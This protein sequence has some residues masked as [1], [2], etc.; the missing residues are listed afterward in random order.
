M[1]QNWTNLKGFVFFHLVQFQNEHPIRKN[2]PGSSKTARVCLWGGGGIFC[3]SSLPT[4]LAHI[5]C[6]SPNFAVQWCWALNLMKPAYQISMFHDELGSWAFKLS[7]GHFL[8]KYPSRAVRGRERKIWATAS[9]KSTTSS[10]AKD[11]L[12][13]GTGR[14]VDSISWKSMR[15]SK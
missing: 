2:N 5:S 9:R 7:W 14:V 12:R 8:I 15:Q 13:F 4:Q 11:A 3:H 6:A 10:K 1:L